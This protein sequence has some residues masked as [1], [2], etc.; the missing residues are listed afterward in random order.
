ME[1]ARYRGYPSAQTVVLCTNVACFSMEKSADL[2]GS[3]FHS[4]KRS[5]YIMLALTIMLVAA[6]CSLPQNQEPTTE[7]I[8]GGITVEEV[9]RL[10]KLA[11]NSDSATEL[12][13]YAK[14]PNE[15]IRSEAAKNPNLPAETQMELVNDDK[16]LVR[17]YLG[18]NPNLD[19]AVAAAL[20]NDEDHRA[21]W[22]VAKNPI[23]PESILVNFI[24]DE[25]AEVQKKLADNTA[26]SKEMMLM[27]AE[28]S[29]AT[30]VLV[31]LQRDNLTEDVLDVIRARPEKTIKD[32]LIRRGYATPEPESTSTEAE[33]T[34]DEAAPSQEVGVTEESE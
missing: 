24:E 31:L 29:D 16:W 26:I 21:R 11:S 20:V 14:H 28:K 3:F 17:N 5:L 12:Q 32:A 8:P 9:Q 23:V 33:T 22:T 6:S 18:A 1:A 2:G 34:A 15:G 13:E 10:T 30:A 7:P 25:N 27:I 19:V 4:M